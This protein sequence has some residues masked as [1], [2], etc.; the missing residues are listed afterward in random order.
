M[1]IGGLSILFVMALCSE[2]RL[3]Y[4]ITAVLAV[5][6]SSAQS[7][8][9]VRGSAVSPSYRYGFIAENPDLWGMKIRDLEVKPMDDLEEFVRGNNIDI[10]VLTIPKD[11]AVKVAEVLVSAGIKAIWNFAHVDLNVPASIPVENVHL[12]DSVLKLS[13]KLKSINDKDA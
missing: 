9:F 11:S 10:A 2:H 1:V 7:L 8:L 12:T 5:L 3:E 4:L 6:L 13:Y